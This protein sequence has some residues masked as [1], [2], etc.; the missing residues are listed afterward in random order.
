MRYCGMG[1]WK[2]SETCEGTVESL[3]SE[4]GSNIMFVNEKNSD[5][6]GPVFVKLKKGQ[7]V[8]ASKINIISSS[9]VTALPEQW[10]SL[11]CWSF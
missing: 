1:I 5:I 9:N 6:T 4:P 8:K 3:Q 10:N 2:E 7:G 11:L